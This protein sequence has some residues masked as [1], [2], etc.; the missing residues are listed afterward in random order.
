MNTYEFALAFAGE[1]WFLTFCAIWLVWGV[2]WIAALL[3]GTA[4]SLII[5]AYRLV[6]VL[7]R[8]WPPA[9]LDADG[10]WKPEPK[11]PAS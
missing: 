5:R 2:F 3:I 4:K 9:H 11:P 7:L 8:G 6:A 1:H 10:D